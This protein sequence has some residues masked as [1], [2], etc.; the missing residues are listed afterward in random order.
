MFKIYSIKDN[1]SGLFAIPEYE[2]S[3][4]LMCRTLKNFVNSDSKSMYVTNSSDFT[5]YRLGEFDEV[6][7]EIK[8]EKPEFILNLSD[9][10]EL[11]YNGESGKA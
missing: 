6:K 8:F 3:D 5:L 4:A 1:V 11:P 2:R 10:K 9:L 7:G